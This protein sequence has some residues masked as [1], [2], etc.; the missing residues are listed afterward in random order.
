M[1]F[2]FIIASVI[3]ASGLPL[4]A[5]ERSAEENYKQH[6][7]ECHGRDGKSQTRLGRKSGAKDLTNKENQAKLTDEDA[8][9]GI[10]LGR[11]NN[12]GEEKM[13][14]FGDRL[15]DKEISDLVAYIRTFA[16]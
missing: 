9:K 8:F 13:E 1:S 7:V 5:A 4:A 14:P 10:K 3:L 11:K 16:R 15:S 6:C 12:K 2:R